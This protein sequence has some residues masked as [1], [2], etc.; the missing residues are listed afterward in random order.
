MWPLL[1]SNW[2]YIAEKV[3]FEIFQNSNI[4]GDT[5]TIDMS[6]VNRIVEDIEEMILDIYTKK[7][8]FPIA[9]HI[10]DY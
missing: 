5:N 6:R 3:Q 7:D 1:K 10:F 4:A 2:F 9:C 8:V